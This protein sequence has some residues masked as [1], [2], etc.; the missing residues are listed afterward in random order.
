[1]NGKRSNVKMHIFQCISAPSVGAPGPGSIFN[2][3]NV[4]GRVR[5]CI[6]SKGAARL[7]KQR[8]WTMNMIAEQCAAIERPTRLFPFISLVLC[9]TFFYFFLLLSSLIYFCA[10]SLF[11]LFCGI[12]CIES[13]RLCENRF[14]RCDSKPH[15]AIQIQYKCIEKP[16]SRGNEMGMH[17]TK[18]ENRISTF[19]GSSLRYRTHTNYTASRCVG[20]V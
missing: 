19:F 15:R 10:L 17:T 14:N 18:K 9:T 5:T 13:E 4:T 16:N 2:I 8:Q 6:G 3:V 11:N 7:T 1:M 12:S 20:Q